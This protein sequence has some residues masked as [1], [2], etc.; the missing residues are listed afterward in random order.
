MI[1]IQDTVEQLLSDGPSLVLAVLLSGLAALATSQ[2]FFHPL[3]KYPG[4][5]PAKFT[6]AYNG[7]YTVGQRLHLVTW[8]NHLKYG[9]VV[10]QGPNKLV[11]STVTAVHDIYRTDKTTKPKAYMA[12]GPGLKT[13]NVF[14]ATDNQLHRQR[15]QL[16]GG[17]LTDAS[18]R[19]FEPTMVKQVDVLL[20]NLLRSAQNPTSTGVDMSEETRRLGLDIAGQLAFGY[21]LQLQT[22][23]KNRFMLT[24]ITK[25]T[26]WSSVFLQYPGARRFRLGL[27]AVKAFRQL[28]EPYFALMQTMINSRMAEEVDAKHDLFSRVAPAL[29]AEGDNTGGLRDSELWAEANLFLTAAG[30][31]VKTALSGVLFYLARDKR[32]YEK[33]ATEIRTVFGSANEITGPALVKCQYLRACI[34]ESLR[35]SPPAP[36][37]LWREQAP[38]PSGQPLIVDGHVIP[39]GTIIGVNIYS[40]HHNEDYFPNPFEY[41]PERWTDEQDPSAKRRMREAFMPFSTG[42]RGCAGKSM[43]YGETG[44]VIAKI[45]WYFDFETTTGDRSQ[46]GEG[47]PGLG[48]GREK[49]GEFQLYDVFSSMHEGPYL[50]FKTRADYWKELV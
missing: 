6:D 34:D 17:I 4:P 25:G 40:L 49:P 23:E 32:I 2:V 36:G 10:R 35:M 31:T 18:L 37:T 48:P 5:I 22:E 24:M 41:S 15:R 38:D 20:A 19:A 13:Y 30:D 27:I 28:R 44:L 45:L 39:K 3:R 50:T 8:Q 14:T 9:P 43:A 7:F 47:H 11:F 33:L 46:I 21:D 29:K 42:P 1:I 26:F 16:V 12:L